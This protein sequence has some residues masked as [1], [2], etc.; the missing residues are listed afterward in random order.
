MLLKLFRYFSPHFKLRFIYVGDQPA[1]EKSIVTKSKE[2]MAGLSET[3][4]YV[5]RFKDFCKEQ[6]QLAEFN[7]L[8]TVHHA[9]ILGNFPT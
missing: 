9:M 8:L 1:P 2:A 3:R 5:K 6:G 4:R 7:V